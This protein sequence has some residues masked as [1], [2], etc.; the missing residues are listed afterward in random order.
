[1]S[2]NEQDVI[3]VGGGLAGLTAARKLRKAGRGVLVLQGRDRLSGRGH[4]GGG[5]V[6][7]NS[8]GE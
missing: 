2:Y 6:D 7:G 5:T 1:M 3:V 8:R 4:R